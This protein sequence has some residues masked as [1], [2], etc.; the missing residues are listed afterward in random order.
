MA[1]AVIAGT[2][3]LQSNQATDS[4]SE[5]DFNPNMQEE[6]VPNSTEASN[7]PVDS[8]EVQQAVEET[9]ETPENVIVT[10][11]EPADISNTETESE[12]TNN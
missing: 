11:T 10:E 12:D 2:D 4:I 5:E 9:A 8:E 6:L 3:I 1:D 7:A